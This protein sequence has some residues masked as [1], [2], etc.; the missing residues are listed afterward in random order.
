MEALSFLPKQKIDK[1]K[2]KIT[3][4]NPVLILKQ[5]LLESTHANKKYYKQLIQTI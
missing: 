4:V 3:G 1:V 5:E 2:K